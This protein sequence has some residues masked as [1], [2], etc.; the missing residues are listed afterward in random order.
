MIQLQMLNKILDTSDKSILELNNIN[1]E[2]FSDYKDEY[3]YIRNHIS[4]YGNVPDK[5]TF[6]N[7]FPDFDIVQVN[8]STNYLIDELYKDR[9]RRMLAKTFNEVKDLL[10]SDRVDDAMKVYLNATENVVKA[11]HISSVDIL[12]D[13]QQRYDAFI[14]RSR[15]FSR[16]YV[17]TGF[18]ELDNIIGGWDR[19]E[20]L[21][22]IVARSN[23]GKTWILLKFAVAAAEQGLNVGIYSGE[24]SERKIGYRI[25]TLISH[26]SNTKITHGDIQVQNTYKQFLDNIQTYIKGSIKVI[27]PTML[28]GPAGVSALRS[29]IEKEHLD[30]LCIDQHSLLEDDR[31]A[32]N[33]VEKASNI[34]NDLKNLQV[35]KQIPIL[36]VSQQ[37]RTST[38]NGVDLSHIAQADRI[39]QDSTIVLFFEQKDGVMTLN[40]V[41][42][43]DSSNNKKL[44]YNLNFDTGM[45]NY[46]PTESD[47][48]GGA[49]CD[50]L[51]EEYESDTNSEGNVF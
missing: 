19:K 18:K 24:M 5:E 17:K 45:F 1:D 8:E 20:E 35:L 9:N 11:K 44:Q 23:M 13:T 41:K 3:N 30:M 34:S 39:G 16:Y 43:R 32:R 12:K 47:A 37:N 31:K 6:L 21:A 46:I 2:F 26:I 28:G 48:L 4:R 15:D 10:N 14:E 38:E 51:R 42:S 33:P 40:L 22:T 7:T 49:S 36:A 50:E 29:F 25:D 27:T